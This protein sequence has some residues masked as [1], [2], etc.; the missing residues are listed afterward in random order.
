MSL[1]SA[2]RM[3]GSSSTMQTVAAVEVIYFTPCRNI[4]RPQ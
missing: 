4:G 2:L 1:A 3:E